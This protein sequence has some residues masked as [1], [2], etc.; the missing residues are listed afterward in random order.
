MMKL[1][2]YMITYNEEKRLEKTLAAATQ[3]ADEIVIVDSGSTDKTIAIAQSYGARIYHRRWTSFADQ[4]HFAQNKCRYHW[5]LSLDADEVLSP[6]LITEIQELKKK[7]PDFHA[8]NLRI[9]SMYPGMRFRRGTYTYCIIRLYDRRFAT[10]RADLLTE[11]RIAPLHPMVIGILRAPV[12]H[13]SLLSLTQH[14]DKINRFTDDVQA[15]VQKYGKK[16]S[17]GRLVGELPLQ[18][19]RYYVIR[20]FFIHGVWGFIAAVNIAYSR[21]LKIA[22]AIEKERL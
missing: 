5:V 7:K 18:F 17:I 15:T 19:I 4:K 13:Y 10:M 1:S 3:V 8:Y 6:E 11:D 12:L 16:Y 21:F 20:R 14:V 9:A 2:L 22:K